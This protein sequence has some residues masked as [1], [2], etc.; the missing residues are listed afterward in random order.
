MLNTINE[1]KAAKALNWA[2]FLIDSGKAKADSTIVEEI[3]KAF[4]ILNK[5]ISKN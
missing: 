4:D 5:S 2:L 1:A 3:R